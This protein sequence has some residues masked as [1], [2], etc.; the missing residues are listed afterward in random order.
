[1]QEQ[2]NKN[3]LWIISN[4]PGPYNQLLPDKEGV[5]ITTHEKGEL[6]SVLQQVDDENLSVTTLII[7]PTK[8]QTNMLFETFKTRKSL[9]T[10][11]IIIQKCVS[12]SH[13]VEIR[14]AI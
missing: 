2:S 3:K 10:R 14:Q 13:F 7:A 1:M 12:L 4:S 5:L 9:S 8:Q 6:E 11:F